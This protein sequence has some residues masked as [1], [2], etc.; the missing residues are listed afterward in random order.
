MPLSLGLLNPNWPALAVEIAFNADPNSTTAPVWTDVT[1]DF[2][3]LQFSAG[4]DQYELGD[5]AAGVL[6]ATANNIGAKYDPTNTASPYW[7]NVKLYRRIR[8]QATWDGVT[9]TLWSGFVERW[10]QSYTDRG[11][12][13]TTPLTAT[14]Q[15]ATLAQQNLQ[16]LLAQQMASYDPSYYFALDEP[17][18]TTRFADTS[19]NSG[20]PQ[21][22]ATQYHSGGTYTAGQTSTL[23]DSVGCV[24]FASAPVNGLY[25]VY[26][27]RGA[28]NNGWAN[29]ADG[30]WVSFWFNTSM[31]APGADISNMIVSLDNGQWQNNFSLVF[32]LSSTSKLGV[33]INDPVHSFA[34]TIGTN[35]N[36]GK[37]HHV[38]YRFNPT[39]SPYYREYWID[40]VLGFTGTDSTALESYGY[41]Y[42]SAG[43]A[44]RSNTTFPFTGSVCQLAV[45]PNSSSFS[46]ANVYAAG[47]SGFAGD[48]TS[49]RVN[50]ILALAGQSAATIDTAGTSLESAASGLAGKTVI[51]A[52]KACVTDENGF[53]YVD[54]SG[55]LHFQGR[56][57]RF[58]PSPTATF[59]EN[60]GEIPYKE[61]V[62]L[63]YGPEFVYND[64]TVSRTGGTT[65]RAQ[66]LASQA[67]YWDRS[68]QQTVTV[69]DDQEVTDR[70]AFLVE[71]YAQPAYRVSKVTVNL[72]GA[73][74]LFS[75]V[76]PLTQGQCVTFT[77]RADATITFPGFLERI[78]HNITPGMW[79]VSFMIS[80]AQGLTFWRL[81]DPTYSQLDDG[82]QIAY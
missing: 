34:G 27:L 61:D 9:T 24:S 77:R 13:G 44:F 67:S 5:T 31:A 36:D 7:P 10:P 37:W 52:V 41:L 53:L 28:N 20:S 40:G 65:A 74:S 42:M 78:E 76:L 73:P 35:V 47:I 33:Q 39:G 81:D 70:A 60:P 79:D 6:N 49:A 30:F 57:G 19:G 51:D 75:S 16:N 11:K 72:A 29:V 64:V 12:R 4:R 71:H 82:Y 14:D 23:T 43:G 2:L 48:T 38:A 1:D 63:D 45:L 68:L 56:Q 80:P 54:G 46:P 15:I 32:Y 17:A 55:V 26:M 62:T 50:R 22:V 3:A 58:N 21:L 18:G 8:V 59:G 69:L 25:E 66:D